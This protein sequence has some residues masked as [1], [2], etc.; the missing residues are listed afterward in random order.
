MQGAPKTIIL[1]HK[2][3]NL[4]KCSLR[5]LE[6][7]GDCCFLKY[8]FAGLPPL[9]NYVMLVME[10]APL[11]TMEDSNKGIFLLDST[12]RYLPKMMAAVEKAAFVEKRVL[13]GHY[14]TAYP[15]VQ[16]DCLDPK[17]GLSTLEALYISYKI[18]GRSLEGL[19][20]HYHWKDQF[21]NSNYAKKDGL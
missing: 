10:G 14:Q 3:E 12:W 6:G 21:L 16:E 5:G 19:L 8:P 20:D 4:K 7:R 17:R 2:K 13:P 18:L 9:D 15:R 1:R 11:L